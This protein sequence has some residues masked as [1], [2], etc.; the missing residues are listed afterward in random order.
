VGGGG[1]G[2][3]K[4]GAEVPRMGGMSWGGGGLR[5]LGKSQVGE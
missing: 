1:G 4:E 5:R 3:G 2:V